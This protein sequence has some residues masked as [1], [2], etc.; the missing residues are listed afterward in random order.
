MVVVHGDEFTTLGLDGDI[1]WFEGKDQE[2]F[3][4]KIRGHL[5]EGCPGP[6][7]IR[8]LNRVVSVDESIRAFVRSRSSTLR[9]THEF[10]DSR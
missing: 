5:G 9:L 6:P 3:E 1:E 8:I 7:V 4:M 10:F 2:S